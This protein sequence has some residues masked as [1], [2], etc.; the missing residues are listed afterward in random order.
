MAALLDH[1][2]IRGSTPADLSVYFTTAI[3][4]RGWHPVWDSLIGHINAGLVP[5]N[6]IHVFLCQCRHPAAVIAALRQQSSNLGRKIAITHF[7]RWSRRDDTFNQIWDAVGETDGLMLL[8]ASLS[9]VQVELLCL[10]LYLNCRNNGAQAHRREQMTKLHNALLDHDSS[11]AHNPDKRPL[12]QSYHLL[13][14]ACTSDVILKTITSN[15]TPKRSIVKAHL[16]AFQRACWDAIFAVPA[17]D[18]RIAVWR[19]VIDIDIDFAFKVL[20]ELVQSPAHVKHNADCLVRSL[21]LPL[22][23]RLTRRRDRLDS[24]VRLYDLFFKCV[25]IEPSIADTNMERLA[26]MAVRAW[27]GPQQNHPLDRNMQRLLSMPIVGWAGPL[28]VIERMMGKLPPPSRFALLKLGLRYGPETKLDLDALPEVSNL[29]HNSNQLYWPAEMFHGLPSRT[30]WQLYKQVRDGAVSGWPV[31]HESVYSIPTDPSSSDILKADTEYFSTCLAS[32]ASSHGGDVE[33]GQWL[34]DA[35]RVISARKNKA[36]VARKP[37]DREKWARSAINLSIATGDVDTFANSLQWA[38]RFNKDPMVGHKLLSVASRAADVL[39]AV[40]DCTQWILERGVHVD[41]KIIQAN[42]IVM[43]VLETA[44]ML[45]REPGFGISQVL[46]ALQLHNRVVSARLKSVNTLIARKLI[47]DEWA[48]QHVWIPTTSLLLDVERF[49]LDDSHKSLGDQNVAGPLDEDFSELQTGRSRHVCLFLDRLAKERDLFWR[50]YRARQKPATVTLPTIWPRGLAVHQ[51]FNFDLD[52]PGVRLS[53]MPYFL[54]RLQA[55][56]FAADVELL[57]P[58]PADEEARDAIGPFVDSYRY[59]LDRLVNL[60]S[61]SQRAQLVAKAWEH[62]IITF[63]ADRMSPTEATRFW[64][65]VFLDAHIPSQQLPAPMYSDAFIAILPSTTGESF[66]VEW[67]PQPTTTPVRRLTS[68]CLDCMLQTG[69]SRRNLPKS[70]IPR[71]DDLDGGW[72]YDPPDWTS[73]TFAESRFQAHTSE[74]VSVPSIW[75]THDYLAALP[76]A[77]RDALGVAAVSLVNARCGVESSLFLKPYPSTD[78][79]RIPALYLEEEFLEAQNKILSSGQRELDQVLGVISRLS[80]AIPVDLLVQLARSLLTRMEKEE[81]E[82]K[83]DP[84][85]QAA[86]L[87]IIKRLNRGDSPSSALEFVRHVVLERQEDSSWHRHLLDKSFL[88]ALS[89]DDAKT[90]FQGLA[91][92]IEEKLQEQRRLA[93]QKKAMPLEGATQATDDKLLAPIIKISTVKMIAQILRWADF[94]D[95][96]SAFEILGSLLGHSTHPDV[97]ICIVESLLQQRA[98]SSDVDVRKGVVEIIAD[99][100]VPLAGSLDERAPLSEET[101]RR[102]EAGEGQLPEFYS[103]SQWTL[104]PLMKLLT[105]AAGYPAKEEQSSEWQEW[106]ERV[107]IP[108]LSLSTKNHMRWTRLFL[109]RNGLSLQV[110]DILPPV[111]VGLDMFLD[112]FERQVLYMPSDTTTTVARLLSVIGAPPVAVKKLLKQV[113]QNKDLAESDAGERFLDTWCYETSGTCHRIFDKG[114]QLLAGHLKTYDCGLPP[115]GAAG[116]TVSKLQ[117]FITDLS[118]DLIRRGDVEKMSIVQTKLRMDRK[119]CPVDEFRAARLN[120]DFSIRPVVES[121]LAVIESYQAQIELRQELNGLPCTPDDLPCEL[122]D[123]HW[124]HTQF[125]QHTHERHA[126]EPVSPEEIAACADALLVELDAT[127][128]GCELHDAKTPGPVRDMVD[129]AQDLYVGKH[130]VMLAVRLGTLE[131]TSCSPSE[132]KTTVAVAATTTR[133]EKIMLQMRWNMRT[134]LAAQLLESIAKGGRNYLE[135]EHDTV[136]LELTPET[137]RDDLAAQTLDMLA[138]W[139]ASGVEYVRRQADVVFKAAVLSNKGGRL[140]LLDWLTEKMKE[141]GLEVEKHNESAKECAEAARDESAGSE[142]EEIREWTEKMKALG[143]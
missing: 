26:T 72:Y 97:V 27:R 52:G 28:H 134:N 58:C 137:E 16:P 75:N 68:T 32:K 104:P 35:N 114:V 65:R 119:F 63:T 84:Y 46:G 7:G 113:R 66:P 8:M 15:K 82:G 126:A 54:S 3:T 94:V 55:V 57:K 87:A 40:P 1:A 92:A 67:N 10:T 79:P 45:S 24:H 36:A 100:I 96:T 64:R 88:R 13:A 41:T 124:Y 125:I 93:Q 142:E 80:V 122:P 77:G 62:A 117:N 59:A 85:V 61:Q 71:R 25:D 39:C 4:D 143:L 128:D 141:R 139:R 129:L 37:E 43:Q 51:L 130:L 23:N 138:S 22:A 30:A 132:A 133:A 116:M 90:F 2:A 121:I 11:T 14:P 91:I 123:T 106:M 69:T 47:T 86:T 108:T 6:L 140:A 89:A 99:K 18:D 12:M 31:E 74:T 53:D 109:Q 20:E 112:L 83:K 48:Q 78:T 107:I 49:L 38:R 34:E 9:V 115:V 102:A 110:F 136:Q 73:Q 76:L 60:S 50:E 5:S 135:S 29:N 70:R 81:K 98:E 131:T 42:Q 21:V 101:W 127:I 103:A 120:W 19:Y 44:A 105:D 33:A 111:P 56:V 17:L 95:R 118:E